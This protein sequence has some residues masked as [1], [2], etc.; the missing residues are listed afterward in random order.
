M[1]IELDPK[2]TTAYSNLGGALYDY[3]KRTVKDVIADFE[4]ARS[5]G[6]KYAP[7]YYNWGFVLLDETN[8][9]DAIAKF[10]K[11]DD[12]GLRNSSLYFNWGEALY[13]QNNFADAITKYR[14]AIEL[15]LYN[16][17]AYRKLE[18]AISKVHGAKDFDLRDSALYFH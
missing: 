9:E 8:F 17:D 4:K 1:D 11:A 3:D 12:L 2:L 14:R 18:E 5:L 6:P 15:D 10:R 16:L 7:I 13:G